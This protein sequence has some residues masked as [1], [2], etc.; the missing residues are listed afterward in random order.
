[1]KPQINV[2]NFAERNNRTTFILKQ[3]WLY[4]AV[5]AKICIKCFIRNIKILLRFAP[6]SVCPQ[7][8]IGAGASVH[9]LPC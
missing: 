3:A 8:G 9:V 4:Y 1:M 6:G 5:D 7:A 2:R